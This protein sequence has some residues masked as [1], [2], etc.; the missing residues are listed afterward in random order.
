VNRFT[1]QNEGR[2]LSYLDSGGE[3]PVVI[4][5]HAHWMEGTTFI[6]LAEKLAAEWRWVAL[7]Q[8]GHGYSDHAASYDREG[9]LSDL[10][11]LFQHLHLEQAFLL[12]N[13]LGGVN[14][15]QYAARRPD[16]VHGLII[17]DIGVDISAGMPPVLAWAGT[18]TNR[19]DLEDRI[20]PRFLPYL[21]DSFRETP[22]GWKLAF[23]PREMMLSGEALKG[24]HWADW[25]ATHC[26]ALVI[27]GS[28]SRV[29]TQE[30]AEEMVSRRANA[31]LA[32]LPGG[33][34]IH[35]DCLAGFAETVQL[36][37]RSCPLL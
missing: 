26:P 20:G 10:D 32:T 24:N 16:R 13:S 18:F 12:G 11:A 5:L 33:H 25:L 28:D 14:A 22:E 17:E 15:Y 27:R 29:T 34:V 36:F 23:E 6:P 2:V 8:R 30:E 4:A 9:Y 21:L 3:L 19:K 37:L 35:F 7:D 31:K 1:Y